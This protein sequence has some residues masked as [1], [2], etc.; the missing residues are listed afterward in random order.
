MS[1]IALLSLSIG[2]TLVVAVAAAVPA[3]AV[4]QSADAA[5]ARAGRLTGVDADGCPRAQN[6]EIIVCGASREN[7]AQRL[8]FPTER[9]AG[10]RIP[11]GEIAAASS[12]PIRQ[13]ACGTLI[14]DKCGGGFSIFAVV[15]FVARLAIGIVDPEAASDPP[16]PIPLRR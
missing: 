16:P 10:A 6:V 2:P 11:A 15:P 7:R 9:E 5:L 8:P 1:R 4:A 3:S 13:G 12:A 14:A